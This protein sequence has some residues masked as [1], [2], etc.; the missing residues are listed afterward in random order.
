VDNPIRY[1]GQAGISRL[2][3]YQD[4]Q[5]GV[6]TDRLV[7]I[8]Q[9]HRIYCSNPADFNDP[10][11]CKPYFDPTL[12]DN[13]ANHAATADSLI[14]TQIGGT[15]ERDHLLRTN[16]AFLKRVIEDY[17]EEQVKF[18]PARWGVYC[19]S[20]DPCITL[21]WSHYSRNHRGICLE[22]GTK[23]KFITALR[24]RYQKEYPP[25][26]IHEHN[27]GYDMLLT[28]SDVWAYEQEYRLL[29]PRFTD[30]QTPL[31]M[32]GNYLSIEPTDLKSIIVGCQTDEDSTKTIRRLRS[33][34]AP[35]VAVRFAVRAVNRY[36]LVIEG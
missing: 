25:L 10:W 29:C 12:L 19:M 14:A 27:V 4:F 3:H 31:R 36:R 20:P 18:I 7:D 26:M 13:P 8:L 17:S 28:K 35:H 15:P 6:L 34:Y 21:M 9:N 22:F 16:V 11:D 30:V 23:A 33:Q 1:A 32:D 24:V 2:Y 5:P